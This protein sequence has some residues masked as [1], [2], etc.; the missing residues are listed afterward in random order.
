M[1]LTERKATEQQL[2]EIA[3]MMIHP[4]GFVN[5]DFN[6]VRLA[7]KDRKGVIYQAVNDTD[8]DNQTFLKAFFSEMQ[9]TDIVNTYDRVLLQL[10]FP[11]DK[12]LMMDDLHSV[13][14]FFQDIDPTEIRW[15]IYSK[16]AGEPA[17][18]D[19]LCTKPL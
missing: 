15:G 18:I 14:Q 9:K 6:D 1:K 17:S 12:P 7:I 8:E 19:L 10:G 2:S 13:N 4:I 5:L 3:D 11:E 16:P